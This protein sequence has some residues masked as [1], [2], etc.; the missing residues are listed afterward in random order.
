MFGKITH[1]TKV[2]KSVFVLL[3]VSSLAWHGTD[4]QSTC[5]CR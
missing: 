5:I 1:K 3:S 2:I 4:Y